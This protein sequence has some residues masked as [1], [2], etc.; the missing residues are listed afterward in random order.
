MKIDGRRIRVGDLV[1]IIGC[2][3]FVDNGYKGRRAIV[4]GFGAGV[5]S[6]AT[7]F[8]EGK[9]RVSWFPACHLEFVESN[10]IDL[11]NAWEDDMKGIVIGEV[12]IHDY[13][14]LVRT[15]G[16]GNI[17]HIF[18]KRPR[19]QWVDKDE[20]DTIP[21]HYKSIKERMGKHERLE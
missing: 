17:L 21:E 20:V 14:A 18:A 3:P 6:D 19:M 2:D 12:I 7:L 15:D 13:K 4:M 11:R 5:D 1:N 9:G 8:I 16:K 10:R